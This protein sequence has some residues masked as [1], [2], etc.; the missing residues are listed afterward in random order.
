MI[1]GFDGII[2]FPKIRLSYRL[3]SGIMNT[4]TTTEIVMCTDIEHHRR[5]RKVTYREARVYLDNV[6]KYGSVLGLD[7]IRN[8]LSELGNPQDEL[9]FIHIAGTNG[10]GSVL[11]FI[12]TILSE[13]GCKVGR[14]ISP[15]VIS[16]LERIQVDGRWIEEETFAELVEKV[17][18]AVACMETNGK[19]TPTV[20]EIET[21]I[22]F[23]YFRKMKCDYVVLETGLGGR[24][25]ATNIIKNT[26]LAVF[27]TISR[28]HMGILGNTLTEIAGEKAGIIKPGCIVVSAAQKAEV[29]AVLKEKAAENGCPI[30]FAEP[31]K[32]VVLEENYRGQTFSCS[33]GNPSKELKD[34]HIRL[35]GKYQIQNVMTAL[36]AIQALR[37]RDAGQIRGAGND[38]GKNFRNRVYISDAVVRQGLE[39]TQWPGRFT[40]IHENP[41]FIVDGAHNEDAARQLRRTL[42]TYFPKKRL[43]Y[44]MG[45]FKD[46]EYEKIAAIMLPL[47]KKIYTIDLP[48]AG[49]TLD[50]Q[51]LKAVLDTQNEK[52]VPMLGA[53][54]TGIA[55]ETEKVEVVG[56]IRSAVSRALETADS[57]D[58]I[59]AFGSL[60]Y[61]GQ[62][63]Q[64][65]EKVQERG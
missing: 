15:T 12:S 7:T 22:A 30:F 60:S 2:F 45:V 61:L 3:I 14:Y 19:G 39:K 46:K 54:E 5:I 49:R 6:S 10:K 34:L 29:R 41:V 1:R 28:D 56:D 51:S 55:D 11:A 24:L 38:A 59:V 58:V 4:V 65:V 16:Y 9:Q 40:C 44:I 26:V 35:A 50:A 53:A 36:E 27:A 31:E 47:A 57:E 20:F 32:A 64:I 33:I 62:V 63:M 13:A 21:A 42:E 48:D 37:G 52:T 18:R 8:L 25:D 17:Q 23:L 43:I